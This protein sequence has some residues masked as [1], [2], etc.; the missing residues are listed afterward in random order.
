MKRNDYAQRNGNHT[1]FVKKRRNQ[2][3]ILF[4]YVD[5]ILTMRDDIEEIDRLKKMFATDFE[6]KDL[7]KLRY[8]FG[9]ELAQSRDELF[10]NQ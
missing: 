7:G 4:V 3:A 5:D 2:V 9:I 8:S 6:L 1:L 10:L